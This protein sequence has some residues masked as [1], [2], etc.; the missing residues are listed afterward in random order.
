MTMRLRAST[1]CAYLGALLFVA[2]ASP[3]EAQRPPLPQQQQQTVEA[4][5]KVVDRLAAE[6]AQRLATDAYRG[7]PVVVRVSTTDGAGVE[8]VVAEFLR[9]RLVERNI[10]AV[11]VGCPARCLE[12]TLLEFGLDPIAAGGLIAGELLPV[13][14][15][16]VPALG[17]LARA[18]GGGAGEHAPVTGLLVT[19]SA[20]DGNR[21]TARGH[22]VAIVVSV[23]GATP[24]RK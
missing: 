18:P 7:L 2:C 22:V 1:A 9:T 15:G 4:V 21:F 17:G 6:T 3:G 8:P 19:F 20:R 14:A 24:E 10:A 23:T 12:I 5:G 11:E 13:A 16:T